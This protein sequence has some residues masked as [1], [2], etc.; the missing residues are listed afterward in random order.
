MTI[1]FWVF[2]PVVCFVCSDV[3]EERTASIF[4]VTELVKDD[5]DLM[6]FEGCN[7][8]NCN[9]SIEHL[10]AFLYV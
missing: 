8:H 2:H 10:T 9:D 7:S 3:S 4:I 1:V 6:G 5:A